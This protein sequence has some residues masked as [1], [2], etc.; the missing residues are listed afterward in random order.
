MVSPVVANFVEQQGFSEVPENS[1]EQHFKALNFQPLIIGPAVL[2]AVLLQSPPLFLGLSG[3]LWWSALLHRW[4]PFSAFHNRFLAA[5]RRL[6]PLGPVPAPRRFA[7]GMAATFM[8][9]AGAALLA[10]WTIVAYVLQGFVLVALVALLFGKFCLGS[11]VFFL[12]RGDVAFANRTLPW[13]RR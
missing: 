8:L 4:N 6:P 5:A 9:G 13:A 3:V 10:G 2:I 1:R 11:Y 12:L 7:M